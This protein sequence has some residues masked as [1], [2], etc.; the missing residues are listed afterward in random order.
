MSKGEKTRQ[1][2]VAKAAQVFSVTGYAGTSMEALTQ[3]TGLTKGGIYNH[4]GSKEA[5]ALEAFDFASLQIRQRFRGLLQD[6][7]QAVERLGAVVLVFQ[8][9]VSDPLLQGG[10]PLLNTATEA[11]DTNPALRERALQGSIEWRRYITQTVRDGIA[12]QELRADLDPESIATILIATLEGA[13]M[14]SKL[15]GDL[16]SMDQAVEHLTLYLHSLQ[17]R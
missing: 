15:A 3:A 5:L 4:F 14:L 6:R 10:C 11:D 17:K 7:H 12:S 8:S 9:L 13:V 16:L 1:N 2:I